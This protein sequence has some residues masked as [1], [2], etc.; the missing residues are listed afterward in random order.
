[1]M[2]VIDPEGGA[3]VAKK[4]SDKKAAQKH[5]DLD[6]EASRKKAQKKTAKKQ[7]A[8]VESAQRT[9][10]ELAEQLK[11]VTK[12]GR[13]QIEAAREAIR[14]AEKKASKAKAKADLAANAGAT[15]APPP[16]DAFED[17]PTPEASRTDAASLTPPLP[18]P[19]ADDAPSEAWTVVRLRALAKDRQV[20]GYT[21]MTKA[22]LLEA[23]RG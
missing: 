12:K 13:A 10:R 19:V 4:K 16:E 5:E 23:L 2:G 15:E 14:V 17:L 9:A 6:A 20:A 18:E 11:K 7:K 1:M 8:A 21:G 22:Q 3:P